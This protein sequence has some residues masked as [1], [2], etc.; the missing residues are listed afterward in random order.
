MSSQVPPGHEWTFNSPPGWPPAPPGWV[1]PEDWKPDPSW[2]PAPDGWEWWI[3]AV[4]AA[5]LPSEPTAHPKRWPVRHK[6]VTIAASIV[7]LLVVAG[8][9][10]AVQNTG[11]ETAN[12]RA[13]AASQQPSGAPVTTSAPEGT[14]SATPSPTTTS[15]PPG[16]DEAIAGA[17][18][19]TA[20][21]LLGTL[22]VKGRAAMTGYDQSQF[23]PAW[24]DTDRNGC[25]TRNDILKRDLSGEV[26]KAGTHNCVV[27]TGRLSPDPYTRR[28]I[29][30][31]RGG[32]SEVDIDHV[33]ALA[34][35]WQ[36]GASSWIFRKRLALANDP[37]NLLA[38]DASANRQKGAGDAATWLPSNKAYRCPYVARQVA[39]KAK[40]RLWVTA[41]ERT[42]IARVLSS[43]P[44][45]VAP[46]G[47]NPTLAP[48]AGTSS[49]RATA[50]KTATPR[51][52]GTKSSR[53][54]VQGVHPGAYCSEHGAYGYTS[55]GTLMQC[56]TS[57][58]DSRYRWRA[59]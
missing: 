41:A 6:G 10:Q 7:A 54:Y 1:P 48:V 57:A 52:T 49:P 37:L 46:K 40:Y 8:G 31:V 56:K 12:P 51:P 43:C 2:P 4:S 24:T 35:A 36:K 15:A 18:P 34:D 59:V 58:S 17:N 5:A 22:A 14:P 42:A 38:V 33:V 44:T 11:S 32:A 30:F 45:Q 16:P 39:V 19:N 25:D 27:L 55:A 21:A 26:F 20:L 47:G 50:S 13:P 9:I 23:G 53:T 28:Q 3:P 29:T